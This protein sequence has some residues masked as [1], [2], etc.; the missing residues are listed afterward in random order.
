MLLTADQQATL[1]TEIA[2][3]LLASECTP[4]LSSVI[5]DD[6]ILEVFNRRRYTVPDILP[7]ADFLRWLGRTGLMVKVADLAVKL[8][9]PI[10]L[11]ASALTIE[12]FLVSPI[13]N[14]DVSNAQNQ[15]MLQVWIDT[16]EIT[17][18][19]AADLISMTLIRVSRAYLLFGHDI[20][21][22]D[23]SLGR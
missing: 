4:F 17:Q 6:G 15:S 9:A 5:D 22:S 8:D 20:T 10:Q 23:V 7:K 1:K 2:S 12:R 19:Q 13:P 21:I 16:G 11:R 18:D 14:F 3:G